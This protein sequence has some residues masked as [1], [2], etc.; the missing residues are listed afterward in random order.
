MNA[1]HFEYVGS[2]RTA[3]PACESILARKFDGDDGRVYT[4]RFVRKSGQ[5][6]A[7]V[8]RF[9][10]EQD[11]LRLLTIRRVSYVTKLWWS[12][13]DDKAMYLVTVSTFRPLALVC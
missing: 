12:F 5:D 2:V 9:R 10:N 7:S 13:E 3:D 4:V 6:A 8:A 11:A 1:N